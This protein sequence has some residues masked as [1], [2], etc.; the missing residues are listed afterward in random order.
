LSLIEMISLAVGLSMDA[1]AVSLCAA[2][3]GFA[4]APRPGIRIAFHFGLFQA[5]M[6]LL[7][8]LAGSTVAPLV[9]GFDH[10]LAFLLLAFVAVR[11]IRSGLGSDAPDPPND[12]TRGANLIMLSV[13]TSID[14]MAVGFSLALLSTPILLPC[15]LIGVVT[16]ALSF[17][18]TRLGGRIGL[19]FGKRMEILGGL[20]L[21]L[22]G[23]RILI[24]HL[25]PVQ[26]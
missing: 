16:F 19:R 18:A 8:W 4:S 10:W 3:S 17:A 7:G 22:I 20:V 25:L 6:P 21:L 5:V 13:A 12:P 11:M 14:A 1:M 26:G 9:A 24:T 15:L 2:A 23:L